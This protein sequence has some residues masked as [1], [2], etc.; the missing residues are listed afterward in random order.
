MKYVI[1]TGIYPP[2]IGGPATAIAAL[3]QSLREQEKDVIVVTYGVP[4][5]EKNVFAVSRKGP[6]WLRYIRFVSA[7]R[8]RLRS[9]DVLLATDVFS[10]GIPARLALL[11]K[12]NTFLL[13]L[14]GEWMWEGAVQQG[15]VH[16]PLRAFWQRKQGGWKKRFALWNYRWI[17][18]RAARIAVTSG[19]LGDLLKQIAPKATGKMTTVWNVSPEVTSTLPVHDVHRPLRLLYI[20]RFARVKNVPFLAH[21]IRDL[22]DHGFSVACT[23]VGDGTELAE[24][25]HILSG[26]PSMV[27]APP[28]A[29][30][31]LPN[32][33]AQADVHVLPSLSDICPNSVLESLALGVPVL[34]TDEHGLPRG[35]PG[36]VEI[37]P[38]DA[39]A[40]AV[41]LH[42]L[43]DP[44]AYRA[45]RSAVRPA[46][47]PAGPT[48]V[49]FCLG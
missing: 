46:E 47:L 18:K 34:L 36:V 35:L 9:G 10:A 4:R 7:I 39:E 27:F 12:R 30:D 41:S 20:G 37:P 25:K 32:L 21:V 14:G 2:E 6:T 49:E 28:T 24:V 43:A 13:R 38:T 23:F 17:M 45:L 40:W 11:L 44:D 33:F 19:L 5:D 1:A 22:F 48:L 29:H 8:R 31:R 15:K 16:E 26:V 3:V 42:R